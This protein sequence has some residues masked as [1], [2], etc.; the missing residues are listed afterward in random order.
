M[1]SPAHLGQPKRQTLLR[2]TTIVSLMTLIS[3]IAG[4]LRDMIIAQLFGAT[5]GM[6]AFY[7]A[8]RIPNFLRRLF[9]EGAFSQAFVPVLAE[10]QQ[11][12]SFDEVR[13]FIAY[14]AGQLGAALA[15]VTILGILS[16]P[17]IIHLFA[18]GFGIHGYRPLIAIE[19][20]RLMF[21]FLMLI[22]LTGMLG[23]VL[24]TYG[25]FGIPALTPVILNLSMILAALYLCP[26]LDVP[27]VGLAWGVL[28]AGLV[29][30]FF[31]LPFLYR[32]H[33]LV[34]P[35]WAW[36][37][38]GV[39]RVLTLMVPA[40]FGVSV[41]QINLMID[42]I[43]ASFLQV[44]S[45]TWLYYT[46]RLTDF[47]LG[48]FGVALATVILPHLARHFKADD[49][50]KYGRSLDWALRLILFIGLPSGLGLALFSMPLI[51]SCFAYG[52]F[53]SVDLIQTQK[54]LIALGLG[55]PAFMLIKVLASAFYARHDIKTP[56]RVAALAMVANSVFCFLLIGHLAHAGLALASTLAGYLNCVTLI[57][58]LKKQGIYQPLTGWGKWLLQ[59]GVANLSIVLYW[60]FTRTE[61]NFWLTKH[62]PERLLYLIGHVGA[63]TII[64]CV[65]LWLLG[66]RTTHFREA[67]YNNLPI[68]ES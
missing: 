7:V 52:A 48:V 61:I 14:I 47:P 1:T 8:F 57:Q 41:A 43:F 65:S 6:D 35:K 28:I 67:H 15:I 20:L 26:R 11:R 18:P 33:L 60:W 10:Y 50:A 19:M 49:Q 54:S 38:V 12:R 45:V 51:A 64:Y 42:S 53:T 62:A 30:F 22:S 27:V 44:G 5:A 13:T 31:Q 2:S 29:Q 40:L 4:F 9:A 24:N 34:K 16:A 59:L 17:L 37:D 36:G 56:V 23:A 39:N 63:V 68:Q 21:P 25:Y 55:V 3:R 46:D 58:K 32:K 66:V